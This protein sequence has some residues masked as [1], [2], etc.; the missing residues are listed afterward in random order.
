MR[1]NWLGLGIINEIPLEGMRRDEEGMGK[2]G[3]RGHG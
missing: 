1:L 2:G 3:M